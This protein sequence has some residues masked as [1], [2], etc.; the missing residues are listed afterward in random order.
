MRVLCIGKFQAVCAQFFFTYDFRFDLIVQE[1][2]KKREAKL[3]F[4]LDKDDIE[5]LVSVLR[6]KY[7][8]P[9]G[10]IGPC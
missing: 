4:E 1:N 5:S 10:M 9:Q 6:L 2:I 8:G 7:C 3:G